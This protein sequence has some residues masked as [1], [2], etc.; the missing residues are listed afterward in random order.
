VV[1]VAVVL[2]QI[3]NLV[4][5]PVGVVDKVEEIDVAKNKNRFNIRFCIFFSMFFYFLFF[6]FLLLKKKQKER[7]K[8]QYT[9]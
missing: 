9:K 3:D 8:E 4:V 7:R 5:D 2:H 6:I 1:E